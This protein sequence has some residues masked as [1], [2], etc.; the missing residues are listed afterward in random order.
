MAHTECINPLCFSS[1]ATVL[2]PPERDGETT[3]EREKEKGEGRKKNTVTVLGYY[4][5][6]VWEGK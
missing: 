1:C 4:R 6:T 3:E 5:P 2:V